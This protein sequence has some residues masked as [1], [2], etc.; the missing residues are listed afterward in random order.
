MREL[1]KCGRE[2]EF[3]VISYKSIGI[4]TF[5]VFVIDLE[6]KLIKNWHEGYELWESKT[7]GFKTESNDFVILSQVGINVMSLGRKQGRVIKD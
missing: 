3:I 2:H 4:N 1:E 5:N 7:Y 6:D